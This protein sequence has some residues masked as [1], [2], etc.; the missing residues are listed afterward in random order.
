MKANSYRKVESLEE[1][2]ELVKKSPFNKVLGGGL[3]LKK[4]N[5]SVDTLIDLSKLGLDKITDKGDFV[6][7]GALV[8]QREFE[9]SKLIKEI[10]NGVLN[11]A[12]SKIMGP[13][14][15]ECAT[16]GG[17]VVGKFGFSD[18][19]TALLIFKVTLVFYPSGEKSLEDYLSE[20]GQTK[21]IL[22]HILIK[23]CHAKAFFKKVAITSLDYP[24]VNVAVKRCPK[25][26]NYSVAVGSR[27]GVAML[28]HEVMDFVNSGNNDFEK[29]AE[30]VEKMKFAD[31]LTAKADYRKHLAKVYVRRGL[32]EVSK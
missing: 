32:E 29:A 11:E 2:Y 14:F 8:T 31:S 7:V 22:T 3:W 5:A 16:I 26:G 19:L 15:R 17:S 27:A 13:A 9:Q 30:L 6:E 4:G 23:K 18:L 1:A 21:E 25:S 24:V 28:A 10:G 12:V 20:V